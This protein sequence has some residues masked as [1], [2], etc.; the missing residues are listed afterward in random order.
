MKWIISNLKMNLTLPEIINYEAKLSQIKTNN[1]LVICPSYP[2]L[3]YFQNSNYQ[4]GSQNVSHL[5]EGALTGEVSAKQLKSLG[6]KYTIVGHFERREK[7]LETDN[8]ITSKL[9]RL[10]ETDICPILCIGELNKDDLNT[11]EVIKINLDNIFTD[12]NDINELIIAYE[13][14]WAIGTGNIPDNQYIKRIVNYIKEWFNYRFG[15]DIPVIYGGSVNPSN[16]ESLNTISNLDGYLLGGTSLDI[17]SLEKII[18]CMEV[19]DDFRNI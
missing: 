6:V 2:Y 14:V 16:I 10:F 19:S 18:N 13:P 7:L 12:I 9:K 8:Q 15:I 11:E 3:T 4:L 17:N 1:N 5:F